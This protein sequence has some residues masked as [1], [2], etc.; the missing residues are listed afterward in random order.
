MVPSYVCDKCMSRSYK[1][2]ITSLTVSF[3]CGRLLSAR[4]GH[5][6]DRVAV[7]ARSSRRLLACLPVGSGVQMIRAVVVS[8]GRR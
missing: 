7:D 8:V 3:L 2:M 6:L 1:S 5:F 4:E